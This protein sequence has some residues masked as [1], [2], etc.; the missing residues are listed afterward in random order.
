[1]SSS[2]FAAAGLTG[3]RAVARISLL[4]VDSERGIPPAG[5]IDP[6]TGSPRYWRY[7]NWRFNQLTFNSGIR[8]GEKTHLRST[9]WYQLFDQTIDQYVD[10]SY[11][12]LDSSEQDDDET[13]GMCVIL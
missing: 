13:L 3:D 11:R 12:V 7:P 6:A 8:L 1:S 9:A 10:R 2:L 5:H 4:S